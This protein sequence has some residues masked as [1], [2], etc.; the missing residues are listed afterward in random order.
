[1]SKICFIANLFP[2][3]KD[4][5]FGSFVGK[6]YA[7]L[8]QQGHQLVSKVVIDYRTSGLKKLFCYV[9]FIFKG[10]LAIGKRNYDFIYFHYLTYSTL[11]LVPYLLF[12][13]P[14]YVVNIHGDD[15]VGSSLLH[16]VMGFSTPLI[17]KYSCAVVVP[18]EYFKDVLLD[19]YPWYGEQKII[20]SPSGGVDFD[21][22]KANGLFRRDKFT[23]GYVSRID[24]GKG[25]LEL[26]EAIAL[27][28]LERPQ[29]LTDF[30]LNMFGTGAEVD[31]L[32]AKIIELNLDNLVS[33]Y[34]AVPHN[35]LASK[36]NEMNALVFPTHRESFGL[37]AVEALACGTPVLASDI[38]PV[39]K[40]VLERVNGLLFEK[41]NILSIS[42]KIVE[43]LCMSESDYND[44]VKN[45]RSS[46]VSYSSSQVAVQLDKELMKL[47]NI[48]D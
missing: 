16:K 48:K 17:L 37:V 13:K 38:V 7:Q 5:S 1:M 8:I 4:P 41:G 46:V 39:N 12:F 19:L 2:S 47:M 26:L 11:C 24:E 25:W 35:K 33:Y 18:S 6:N 36:Y 34:G 43:M 45:T 3:K 27:I 42:E 30:Q 10:I 40:I 15:L 31:L 22:F 9:R 20:I 29:L 44:L 21:V 28:N 23:L 14:K 32:E